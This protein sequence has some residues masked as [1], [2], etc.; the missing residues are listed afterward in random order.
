MTAAP[1]RRYAALAL[2]AMAGAMLS[3]SVLCSWL[4][5]H[6]WSAQ[7]RVLFRFVCHGIPSRCLLLFG[8]PMPICARCT[9][10]YGGL[11]IGALLFRL[12]PEMR[13]TTAR[14]VVALAAIPMAI[15]G[16]TQLIR[17][18]ESTNGLRLETGLVAGIAI[19][20]WVLTAAEA[21][22]ATVVHSS[23]QPP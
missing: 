2:A 17:L 13:E 4:V 3:A 6:G 9:A 19:A 14:I 7:W 5:G 23:L 15:D 20:L 1:I 10:I 16:G 22:S 11:I 12:I 8:V 21:R 18:R